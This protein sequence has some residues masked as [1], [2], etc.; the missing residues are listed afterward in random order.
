LAAKLTAR[1]GGLAVARE[2][3]T[4]AGQTI[5]LARLRRALEADFGRDGARAV[6]PI[7][8]RR[9]GQFHLVELHVALTT[10]GVSHFPDRAAL[11]IPDRK[12]RQRC[13][14]GAPIRVDAP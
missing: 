10:D 1:T 2:L 8:T 3:A 14:A 5:T 9:D 7:C 13:P 4:D 12:V 6:L 11:L